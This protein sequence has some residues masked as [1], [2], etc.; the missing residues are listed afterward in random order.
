MAVT[1]EVENYPGLPQGIGGAEL[2]QLMQEQAER[3]GTRVELDEV[4]E[5]DLSTPPFKVKTY[6]QEYEAQALI[7]ARAPPLANSRSLGRRS[8]RDGGLL[9]CHL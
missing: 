3:F 4:V 1:Q 2:A 6:S 5:V 7:V 9:L 8:S